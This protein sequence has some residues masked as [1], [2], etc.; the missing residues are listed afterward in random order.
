MILS[1]IKAISRLSRVGLD[2]M[3]SK[4]SITVVAI[5][6][7]W[8]AELCFSIAI[9]F[10]FFRPST[11][12]SNSSIIS[13]YISSIISVRS[14]CLIVSLACWCVSIFI[15]DLASSIWASNTLIIDLSSHSS[16]EACSELIDFCNWSNIPIELSFTICIYLFKRESS[17]EA[18]MWWEVQPLSPLFWYIPQ[19][20]AGAKSARLIENIGCPQSPHIKKPEYGL[21][22]FFI[23]R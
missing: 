17:I 22:Y 9:F 16:D 13:E 15:S 19:T 4:T 2:K 20:Y 7:I 5:L 18:L 8:T 23:P 6:L 14:G 3:L 21:S 11:L 1:I 12:T 10:W